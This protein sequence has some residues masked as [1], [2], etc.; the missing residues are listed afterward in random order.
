MELLPQEVINYTEHDYYSSGDSSGYSSGDLII[1]DEIVDDVKYSYGLYIA[2]SPLFLIGFL[3]SSVII[4]SVLDFIFDSINN[5][6]KNIKYKYNIKQEQ[7]K[8]PI[9]NNKLNPAFIKELNQNNIDKVKNKKEALE[10]SICLTE[11]NIENYKNNKTDLV[12]LNCSHVYH[13]DCLNPW[14]KEKAQSFNHPD[15]PYCR[16]EIIDMNTIK[17]IYTYN[18]VSNSYDSDNSGYSSGGYLDE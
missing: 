16:N 15:C 8:L 14:V 7:K 3:I 11:I 5:S 1:D 4:Y 13:K 12:F 2:L 9:Y 18:Q 10:C 17:Q 6:L